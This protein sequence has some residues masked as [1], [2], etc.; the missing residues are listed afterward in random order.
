MTLILTIGN[1]SG[2]YQSSDYQLT[3]LDS[4]APV[5][6]RAG[7]KQ[8]RALFKGLE[9]QLAFTGIAATRKGSAHQR[10]IDSLSETLKLL[11]HESKLQDICDALAR[12][13]IEVTRPHG[14]RGVLTIVIIAATVGEPFRV[15][16]ISNA[17]WRKRPPEAKAKFT[18]TIQ[19]VT[20][21]FDLISGYR[22]SVS[23][24]QRYL[25]RALA[26][27]TR[28][29]STQILDELREINK[30]A[31]KHSR[32]YVSE[33]CWLASQVA[34]GRM[35]RSAGRNIGDHPGDMPLLIGGIDISKFVKENFRSAP[36]EEMRL[37]QTVSVVAGPGDGTPLPAPTGEPRSFT[38]FGSSAA[39]AM[40]T[41]TG[42]HGASIEITQLDCVLEM[43]CN[44]EATVPFAKVVFISGNR[45]NKD[46]PKPLLPWSQLTP[47]LMIDGA[48][49]P[50]GWEY[51]VAYWIEG[52]T[53]RVTIPQSSRSIRNL[54]FLG[55]DDE[56]VIVAPSTT[57]EFTWRQPNEAPS[58][59]LQAR[60]WWRSR[61]D[62]THG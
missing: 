11:P 8:L 7:S 40:L 28:K 10:T 27:D 50:R 37:Q 42:D 22:D 58:A 52:S 44:E 45:T 19:T 23:A 36:G 5:S 53:H 46:F 35:R 24:R 4:A 21:A 38:L 1:L 18:M 62:G 16:V 17:N 56:I 13:A 60:I 47:T 30:I 57:I 49:V 29:S 61:L 33:G 6:D 26:R 15:A 31:A 34:D 12:R 14:L 32:G 48:A 41:P 25:L 9:V 20:K 51:S 39:A 59:I 2:V 55:A 43:R 54:A 3:D